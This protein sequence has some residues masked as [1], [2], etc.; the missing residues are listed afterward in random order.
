MRVRARAHWEGAQSARQRRHL[1]AFEH[2][3]IFRNCT[4]RGMSQKA[5]GRMVRK[6]ASGFKTGVGFCVAEAE[7]SCARAG[8]Q[9][10][11]AAEHDWE[12]QEGKERGRGGRAVAVPA[13]GDDVAA[14]PART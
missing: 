6:R 10:H 3:Y 1:L 9:R 11:N 8:C 2:V 5:D 14:S 7:L 13:P 4:G 12:G